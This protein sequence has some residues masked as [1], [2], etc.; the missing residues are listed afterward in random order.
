MN[1][2]CDSEADLV[3]SVLRHKYIVGSNSMALVVGK[4]LG[5]T[6]LNAIIED[7]LSTLPDKYI[8][9]AFKVNV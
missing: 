8:G 9:H 7:I 5:K 3:K 4:I 6:A 2:L 1:V